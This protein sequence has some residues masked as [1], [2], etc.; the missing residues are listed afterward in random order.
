[1]EC[2]YVFVRYAIYV[3]LYQP[4]AF[5]R[6]AVCE[7][8]TLSLAAANNCNRCFLLLEESLKLLN[9]YCISIWC[10]RLHLIEAIKKSHTTID[11]LTCLL[12]LDKCLFN[13]RLNEKESS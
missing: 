9:I 11:K 13:I 3:V 4:P 2:M 12:I 8:V 5:A 6:Q 1:M 10:K 7:T